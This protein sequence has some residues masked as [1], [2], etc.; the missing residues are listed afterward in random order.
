MENNYEANLED[1]RTG[2][3]EATEIQMLSTD[4]AVQVHVV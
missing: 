2:G 1:G 4:L 3:Y